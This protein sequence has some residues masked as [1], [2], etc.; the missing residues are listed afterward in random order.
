MNSVGA[1]FGRWR[2]YFPKGMDLSVYLQEYPDAVLV[3]GMLQD[4]LGTLDEEMVR[5][6]RD[7]PTS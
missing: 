4:A 3:D 5:R 1:H 6:L 2:Q 7:P